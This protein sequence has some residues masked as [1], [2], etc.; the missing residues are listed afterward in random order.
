M[1]SPCRISL[2]RRLSLIFVAAVALGSGGCAFF[3]EG[4]NVELNQEQLQR[5]VDAV[6]PLDN[7]EEAANVTVTLS[8]PVVTLTDG[9]DRIGFGLDIAVTIV[10]EP[11]EG[12]VAERA[13]ERQ[14]ERQA[15]REAER[16]QAQ[17]TEPEG[18]RGRAKAKVRGKVQD[19]AGAA[20]ERAGAAVQAKADTIAAEREP[21]TLTG[22]VAV[23]SGIRYDNDAGQL[24]LDGVNIDQL[25]IDQ[26]PQR[27]NAPVL[28]L[29]S[30]AITRAL[31]E[32]PIYTIDTATTVGGIADTLLRDITIADGVLRITIGVG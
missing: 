9:G 11:G 2:L 17:A 4:I 28:R 12:P 27:F 24:F 10:L 23:S 3:G 22:T 18:R 16:E 29:S 30:A 21:T 5:I 20:R 14:A 6:F 15:E 26:L 25:D 7:A 8:Q 32:T 19:S 13:E 1:T 31:Q